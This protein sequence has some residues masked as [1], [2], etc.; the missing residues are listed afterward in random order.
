MK[1]SAEYPLEFAAAVA[2]RHQKFVA[3]GWHCRH[4]CILIR[5][6]FRLLQPRQA[7]PLLGRGTTARSSRSSCQSC[8]TW[9]NLGL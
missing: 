2:D 1:A 8:R 7:R 4:T 9:W 5:Q 3:A 6:S